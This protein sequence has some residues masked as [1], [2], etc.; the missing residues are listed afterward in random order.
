MGQPSVSVAVIALCAE[1]LVIATALLLGRLLA[2]AKRD[3]GPTARARERRE[4]E[5][6]L[7]E[8]R[9]ESVRLPQCAESRSAAAPDHC[10]PRPGTQTISKTCVSAA[11]ADERPGGVGGVERLQ[12]DTGG[13]CEQGLSGSPRVYSQLS[14]E[15]LKSRGGR[16]QQ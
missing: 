12:G 6:L 9:A 2:A 16:L 13:L 15:E 5:Q 11:S 8:M 1:V 7:R 10:H 4:A 14:A 3:G